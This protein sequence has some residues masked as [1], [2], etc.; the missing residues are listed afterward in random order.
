MV[1]ALACDSSSRKKKLQIMRMIFHPYA[2]TII[3]N[4]GVIDDITDITI[5]THVKFY[6]NWFRGFG[7][8][9]PLN[10][11]LAGS[12]YNSVSMV[13]LHYDYAYYAVLFYKMLNLH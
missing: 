6:V 9:T 8:V 11:G 3:L 7:T 2:Q 5:Y 10:L 13:V 4:F 12:S 1:K